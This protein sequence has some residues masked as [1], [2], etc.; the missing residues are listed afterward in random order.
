M[1]EKIEDDLFSDRA[2]R[3]LPSPLQEEESR[4][5]TRIQDYFNRYDLEN[6]LTELMVELGS[7][8][9][10][11]PTLFMC[12]YIQ[13]W[14]KCVGETSLKRKAARRASTGSFPESSSAGGTPGR[15]LH[16]HKASSPC[17][18]SLAHD[19]SN[20]ALKNMV[21]ARVTL[22]LQA[23]PNSI[24]SFVKEW[25][26]DP[27]GKVSRR[28]SLAPSSVGRRRLSTDNSI[29]SIND[30]FASNCPMDTEE[31]PYPQEVCCQTLEELT[32]WDLDCLALTEK[33]L[34]RNAFNLFHCWGC[35]NESLA[36]EN[37]IQFAKVQSFL[38]SVVANYNVNNPYHNFK[39][40]YS[41]LAAV[42]RILRVSG[43]DVFC[44]PIDEVALLIGALTH[45]VGH[46]G[47]NN[48]YYIKS[49]HALA[50]RYN[51][52]AVLENMHAAKTFELLLD[53]ANNFVSD[54]SDEQFAEFRKTTINAILATDMKVHFDLT[55]KL[56]ELGTSLGEVDY[57]SQENRVL[58]HKCV[59]HAADISNPVLPTKQYRD[60]SYR[61]MLEF[62]R[63]A[64]T[65]KSQGLPF[66][67]F[68][69]HHPDNELEFAKLQLGF[70]SFVAAPLWNAMANIWDDLK[71][72]REQMDENE[73]YFKKLKEDAEGRC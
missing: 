45:D 44:S 73:R 8:M 1:S 4:Q 61:V 34:A 11:D 32:S 23:E 24:N 31:F 13:E 3:V 57:E 46:Q 64:E 20:A 25:M 41:V 10:D 19:F 14:F 22:E 37:V 55:T 15:S 5:V 52:I 7:R 62:Y 60:W 69:Q 33:E 2:L 40:A 27:A 18:S 48:D 38:L 35:F 49:R 39:H 72:R 36:G 12:T 59:V 42:A 70:I 16:E 67:P 56:Q 54:W 17:L 26:E 29:R 68:M 65:E 6:L 9:P 71:G 50:I 47:F 53:E 66:A 63:Q 28:P 51:D 30:M 21:M 58:V 43:A